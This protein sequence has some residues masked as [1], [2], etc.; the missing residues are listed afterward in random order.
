MR[1]KL[2]NLVVDALRARTGLHPTEP[3]GPR[4]RSSREAAAKP[5]RV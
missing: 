3:Q 4:E 1:V 2:R 5:S